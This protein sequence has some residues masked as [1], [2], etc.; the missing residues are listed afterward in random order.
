MADPLFKPNYVRPWIDPKTGTPTR[1]MV[2]FVERLWER[3][4][5]V[6]SF[7]NTDL[8][9]LASG[10]KA[11][12]LLN[13][14]AELRARL[15]ILT[16]KISPQSS[17]TEADVLAIAQ[18]SRVNPEYDRRDESETLTASATINEAFHHH[19]LDGS[20]AAVT[21]TLPDPTTRVD[22][23]HVLTC[24][25]ASNVCKVTGNIDGSTQTLTIYLG[26]SFSLKSNGAT[27]RFH[28]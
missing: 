14:V 13:E 2:E 28:G 21:A 6:S 23:E 20:S 16:A 4:G 11:S 10:K 24:V 19:F 1:V 5:G 3:A 8:T 18:M 9:A 7:T 27:W 25:D 12:E 26:E 22:E 17:L 15:D